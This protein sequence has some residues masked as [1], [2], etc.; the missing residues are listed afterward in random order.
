MVI[1]ADIGYNNPEQSCDF[2][3]ILYHFPIGISFCVSRLYQRFNKLSS[4]IRFLRF[5]I[6]Y[7]MRQNE[8]KGRFSRNAE[9][10]NPAKLVGLQPIL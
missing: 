1:L 8:I 7:Y 10:L 6:W 4:T 3:T 2:Q 5:G 9:L